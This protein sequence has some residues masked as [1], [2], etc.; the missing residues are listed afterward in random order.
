MNFYAK[1]IDFS[2]VIEKI[3]IFNLLQY[4]GYN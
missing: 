1:F 3:D 2:R 4:F